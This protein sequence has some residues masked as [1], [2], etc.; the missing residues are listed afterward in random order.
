MGDKFD[1]CWG[2]GTHVP[3]KPTFHIEV[4]GENL[5]PEMTRASDLA[6]VILGVEKTILETAASQGIEIPDEA[7]VSLVGI[8][9][10]STKLTLAAALL[11]LPVVGCVSHAV[12][13]GNYDN[14]PRAAHEALHKMSQHAVMRKWAIR[15]LENPT[16]HI[17][18]AV[19]SEEHQVPPPP[20]PPEV[21]GTTTLYGRCI[22]VGGVRPKAEISLHQGGT[23]FIDVTEHIAKD[24]GRRLYDE[25][26]IIGEA[27][28][29][30]E[31]WTIQGFM[32]TTVSPYCPTG[33]ADAFEQLAAAA[34]AHWDGVDAIEY[35][36]RC[37]HGESGS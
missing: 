8:G 15:F 11:V 35:V 32:A 14:L 19:I 30:T 17:E 16:A 29:E 5:S 1:P 21:R 6:E 18:S 25:V 2:E 13:S 4:L 23:L 12:S 36:E 20:M 9:E 33:V 27:T 37:R 28:W 31:T 22:R 7:L 3:Q 24:L 26:C 10:G 34:G